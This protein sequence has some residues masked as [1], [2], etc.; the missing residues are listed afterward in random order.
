MPTPLGSS[1]KQLTMLHLLILELNTVYQLSRTRIRSCFYHEWSCLLAYSATTCLAS[2]NI[3]AGPHLL[4]PGSSYKSTPAHARL[5]CP[6][7]A[8]LVSHAYPMH[9]CIFE[10]NA[11]LTS[12]LSG[13][14][15]EFVVRFAARHSRATSTNIRSLRESMIEFINIT[16]RLSFQQ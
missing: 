5:R 11:A 14:D 15:S 4:T 6:K 16:L 7:V 1:G 3:D 9:I 10:P 12:S 2:T 13:R 8:L